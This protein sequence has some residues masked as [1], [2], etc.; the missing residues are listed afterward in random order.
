MGE[1]SQLR[2]IGRRVLTGL[3]CL[4]AAFEVSQVRH[5]RQSRGCLTHSDVAAIAEKL[6]QAIANPILMA[7]QEIQI[8][9][10][11]GIAIYPQDGRIPTELISRADDA[12]YMAKRPQATGGVFFQAQNFQA[13]SD[14]PA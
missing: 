5:P 11:V 9:A 3:P 13:K 8:S 4:D 7:A 1:L 6:S 12:M 2:L 14:I 10:S